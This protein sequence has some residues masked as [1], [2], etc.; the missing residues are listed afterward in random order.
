[1]RYNKAR[2]NDSTAIGSSQIW[3]YTGA[4][5]EVNGS[6]TVTPTLVF[7]GANDGFMHAVHRGTGT[8]AFK[9]SSRCL[10]CHAN[11]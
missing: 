4:T 7:A 1:M 2:L 11:C 5:E 10:L 6:P 3:N 8:L 9:V